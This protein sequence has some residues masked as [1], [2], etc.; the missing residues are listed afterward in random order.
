MGQGDGGGINLVARGKIR[1]YLK[2]AMQRTKYG[3][4]MDS[5]MSQTRQV[6]GKFVGRPKP[7]LKA[8]RTDNR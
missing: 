6:V 8:R 3:F 4:A 7:L 5:T 2:I 1:Q